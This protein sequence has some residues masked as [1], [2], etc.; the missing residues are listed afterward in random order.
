MAITT[1]PAG[2]RLCC[3]PS[4]ERVLDTQNYIRKFLTHIGAVRQ[5]SPHTVRAYHDDLKKLMHGIADVP[6]TEV[7]VTL[8]KRALAAD[9]K[10]HPASLARRLATWRTFFEYL[11]NERIITDNPARQVKAPKKPAHLPKAL[12]PDEINAFLASPQATGWLAVRDRAIR[13]LLYSSALRL[14]EL[15]QLNVNDVNLAS[16]IVHVRRGKGGRGRVVPLGSIAC[17]ALCDWLLVRQKRLAGGIEVALFVGRNTTRL[18]AR[19]VQQRVALHA[20]K[21]GLSRHVSP[22]MLRHSCASHFL[23]SSG[24]LRATQELLGHRNIATTQIY[25]RLDFQHLAAVYDR[26]HPRA[27]KP[28]KNKESS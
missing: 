19:A 16:S 27:T 13:E 6:L 5:F 9:K 18:T 17:T 23:Q 3:R 26:A 21:S 20:E 12:S 10:A 8:I 25:T 11:I 22:H 28:R 15:T 1:L 2:W 7:S 4:Y 14:S 24:D